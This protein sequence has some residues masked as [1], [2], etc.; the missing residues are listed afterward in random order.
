MPTVSNCSG[1][2]A[3]HTAVREGN[4]AVV[5]LLLAHDANV[6]TRDAIG[7]TPLIEA[8]RRGLLPIAQ[9]LLAHGV[10]PND[11]H[12]NGDTP[13]D[14]A[15]NNGYPN[16]GELLAE[17]G[18]DYMTGTKEFV[19]HTYTCRQVSIA[20]SKGHTGCAGSK[21]LSESFVPLLSE[22]LTASLHPSID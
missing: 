22:P 16:L 12:R 21:L 19:F 14:F 20:A 3:L 9:R 7:A 15:V 17:Y 6:N 11:V 2:T 8:V 10:D 5:A 18:A 1:L 13:V 4:D